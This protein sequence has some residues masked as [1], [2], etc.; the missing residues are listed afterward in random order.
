VGESRKETARK[1]TQKRWI[2]DL[3][4]IR[5][6]TF[7]ISGY[8]KTSGYAKG[9]DEGFTHSAP[10]SLAFEGGVDKRGSG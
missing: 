5:F 9:K 7:N 8:S 6:S 1:P 4:N 10:R 2:D 3:P